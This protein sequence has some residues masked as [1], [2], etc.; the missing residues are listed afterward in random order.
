MFTSEKGKTFVT[1]DLGFI[2]PFDTFKAEE[3]PNDPLAK[4]VVAYMSNKDLYNVD[5]NFT[6]FPSQ[7]FKDSFGQALG[8]Y[9]AGAMTFDEVKNLF[10]QYWAEQK[11]AAQ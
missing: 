1:K 7:T 5:W 9:T 4:E 8:Q 11:K 10:V 3:A 6:S 2:T